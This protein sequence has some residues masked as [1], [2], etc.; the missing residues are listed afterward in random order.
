MIQVEF[1]TSRIPPFGFSVD[2]LRISASFGALK[3]LD[4]KLIRL[5]TV[6]NVLVVLFPDHNALDALADRQSTLE[7]WTPLAL[8]IQN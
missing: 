4:P 8:N 2:Y 5:I 3:T 7:L 1:R 6:R